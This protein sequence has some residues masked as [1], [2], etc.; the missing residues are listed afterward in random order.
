MNTVIKDKIRNLKED[1]K[2]LGLKK[3]SLNDKVQMQENFIEELD[4][5]GKQNIAD[6]EIKRSVNF[7]VEENNWMGVNEEKNERTSSLQ[8]K[9]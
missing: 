3:E 7:L 4:A 2:V 1:I 8:K 5:R 6:K 9:T